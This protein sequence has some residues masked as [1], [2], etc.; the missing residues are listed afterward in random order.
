[1]MVAAGWPLV[2]TRSTGS[3]VSVLGATP[4]L[5]IRTAPLQT[6]C[7]I[8]ILPFRACLARR[9][10]GACTWSRWPMVPNIRRRVLAERDATG[11]HRVAP[12]RA[13]TL[14]LFGSRLG[15]GGEIIGG[16]LVGSNTPSS[17]QIRT[18]GSCHDHRYAGAVDAAGVGG[19]YRGRRG[20]LPLHRRG[21]GRCTLSKRSRDDTLYIAVA[22]LALQPEQ[23]VVARPLGPGR[24]GLVGD[25]PGARRN[26]VLAIV[27]CR[28]RRLRIQVS[29]RWSIRSG[30]SGRG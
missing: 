15:C 3:T 30:H 4:K 7:G 22:E 23:G 12:A 24:N 13:G 27:A 29:R 20:R 5:H 17:H 2:I 25:P 16:K 9:E 28:I 10:K 11:S 19:L 21:A 8:G 18:R 26:A 6:C 1:M 14:S